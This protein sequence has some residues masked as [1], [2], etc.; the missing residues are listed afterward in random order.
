MRAQALVLPAPVESSPLTLTDLPDPQPGPG[1]ILLRVSACGVCHTDLH[2]VE[3]ELKPA[4]LPIVPGHQVVGYVAALG[5]DV[6]GWSVG[7]RA[8][9]FWL[10][11][12]CGRCEFCRRGEENLC[13]DAEFTGLD[14]DGGY[15]ECLLVRADYALRIPDAFDDISAAPLL[16]AGI[17]GYR[18]LRKVEVQPGET[19]GLFG[20]GASAHLA[21]QVARHWNCRVFVFTRGAAHRAH[22]LAL[23]AEWAGGAEDAAPAALDRAILFAPA[24]PLVPAALSRLRPGGTLA[25][26]AVYLSNIPEFPYTR[27][28]GERT[29]RSVANATRRDAAEFLALAAEIPVRAT[30]RT[31][32]LKEANHVLRLLKDAQLDGAAVLIPE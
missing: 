26:N 8:G 11:R 27:L 19:I 25:V 16:C 15:A 1:Q 28:Y 12:S 29:V 9:A 6:S 31:F 22:A 32:G 17:I 13:P 3:G 18:S 23:G 14:R 7:D 4:R 24:G 20:F 2:I 21:L 30:V 5:A 10:Y